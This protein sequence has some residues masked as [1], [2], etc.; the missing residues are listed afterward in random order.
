M[1]RYGRQ[2]QLGTSL[3][4][5]LGRLDRKSRGGAS[6]ARVG[7]AWVSIVGPSVQRHTTGAY[8]REGVLIVYVDSPAWATELS[9]MS[10]RYRGAINEEIGQELVREIR[11]TVSRKVA[12]Q[13][14]IVSLEKERTDFYQ[15]DN[16]PS[17]PL[18]PAE[19]AQVEASVEV[20]PDPELREAVLRATIKDL[21]WKR[22][23]AA[24]NSREKPPERL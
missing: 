2:T 15:E 12:E 17:I 20:I 16:V 22:G 3:Q 10:E 24:R 23:I 7:A 5:I 13:H 4:A 8:M 19:L 14:R 21:E 18:E 1:K 6:S 11:F 9:A